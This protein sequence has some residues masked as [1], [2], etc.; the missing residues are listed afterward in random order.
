MTRRRCPSPATRHPKGVMCRIEAIEECVS[1]KSH[2]LATRQPS[3][4]LTTEACPSTLPQPL[5]AARAGETAVTA[6][7]VP[8]LPTDQV[9]EVRYIA[10]LV[11][12]SPAK[13][14]LRPKTRL[15]SRK[16]SW[17][18]PDPNVSS[19]SDVEVGE[20]PGR[21]AKSSPTAGA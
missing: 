16:A 14:P 4:T 20:V 10:D 15:Q 6:L 17:V 12:S 11:S 2:E 21:S 7:P 9:P 18:Y 13:E 8:A 3:T 5:Q 1:R 19:D